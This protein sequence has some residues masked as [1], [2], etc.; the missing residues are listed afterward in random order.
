M[1][2]Q[3][4]A[5][6]PS[7]LPVPSYFR[8]RVGFQAAIARRCAATI[9]ACIFVCDSLC[10]QAIAG[11]RGAAPMMTSVRR[12]AILVAAMLTTMRP[13]TAAPQEL[14]GLDPNR[15]AAYEIESADFKDARAH[16]V[17]RFL[18]KKL[19]S[20]NAKPQF[21]FVTAIRL[22]ASPEGEPV[23]YALVTRYDYPTGWTFR[24]T[25]DLKKGRVIEDK[26]DANRLT[27]LALR[28]ME[29][30][31]QLVTTVAGAKIS[32]TNA[33]MM[34][35]VDHAPSSKT[36]GHRLVIVSPNDPTRKT[37]FLVDLTAQDVLNPNH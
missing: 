2:T 7:D 9:Q 13:V 31:A 33:A 37:R 17:K 26:A 3:G 27:P 32:P 36:R 8:L 6:T 19:P 15:R 24:R 35:F 5:L 1:G 29:L 16:L 11:N 21:S 25:V 14:E 12:A 34:T 20:L 4:Q 22:Y 18:D 28:E 23:R 30:A 10:L